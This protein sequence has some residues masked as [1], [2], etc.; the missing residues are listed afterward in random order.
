LFYDFKG[1]ILSLTGFD[2]RLKESQSQESRPKTQKGTGIAASP[3]VTGLRP[4]IP[5]DA[6]PGFGGMLHSR[7]QG[8]ASFASVTG[9][10]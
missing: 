8:H 2:L 5:K 7:R 10:G 4:L 9:A 6:W 3:H 1:L